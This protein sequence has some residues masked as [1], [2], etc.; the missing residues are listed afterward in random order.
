M[1]ISGLKCN[2]KKETLTAA[3]KEHPPDSSWQILS[4][5]LESRTCKINSNVTTKNNV[6]DNVK[7]NFDDIPDDSRASSKRSVGSP[8]ANCSTHLE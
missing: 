6:K 3:Y 7:G 4:K 1:Q 5:Y 8:Q 2:F